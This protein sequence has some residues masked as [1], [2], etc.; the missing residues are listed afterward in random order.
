MQR[1]HSAPKGAGSSE[2]TIEGKLACEAEIALQ[3]LIKSKSR[4]T[5][6]TIHP[7]AIIENGAK[8]EICH[9]WSLRRH[10]PMCFTTMV[11]IYSHVVV[12]GHTEIGEKSRIFPG[13]VIGTKN[14]GS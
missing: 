9:D 2:A 14:T 8:L 3:W 7:T 6:S 13:A 5:M 11:S 4:K 1:I 10:C 12:D